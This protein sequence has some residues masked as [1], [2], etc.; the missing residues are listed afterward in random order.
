[1]MEQE[2]VPI[3]GMGFA[4]PDEDGDFALTIQTPP[5]KQQVIPIRA[6][7]AKEIAEGILAPRV[8]TATVAEAAEAAAESG[9]VLPGQG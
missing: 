5:G 6:A 3:T 4:G 7:F 8:K 9:I 1:M 2:I